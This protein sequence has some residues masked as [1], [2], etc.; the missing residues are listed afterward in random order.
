MVVGVWIDGGE[1]NC[2]SPA[3]V[4]GAVGVV[5]LVA[6]VCGGGVEREGEARG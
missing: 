1:G 4:L 3:V 5:V 6:E 2:L